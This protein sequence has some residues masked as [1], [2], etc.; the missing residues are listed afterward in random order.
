MYFLEAGEGRRESEREHLSFGARGSVPRPWDHDLSETELDAHPTGPPGGPH[1]FCFLMEGSSVRI[2][3]VPRKG[4]VC[5]FW[6]PANGHNVQLHV[7]TLRAKKSILFSWR[8]QGAAS[9]RCMAIAT[10]PSTACSGNTLLQMHT[11]RPERTLPG[12]HR[13]RGPPR[14]S[15]TALLVHV[16][17]HPGPT[18]L[19]SRTPTVTRH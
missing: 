10:S 7:V 1:N 17:V 2:I 19:L 9:N 15:R 5:L 12:R 4:P 8:M 16:A 6:P 13:V 18:Q 11:A 14:L 3:L